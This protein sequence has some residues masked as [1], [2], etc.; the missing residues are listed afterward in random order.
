MRVRTHAVWQS[1][2]CECKSNW[3]FYFDLLD[4]R[5]F[6]LRILKSYK[7]GFILNVLVSHLFLYP[8]AVYICPSAVYICPYTYS[9][10]PHCIPFRITLGVEGTR[11]GGSITP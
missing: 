2:G 5:F 8:S 7:F 4:G 6:F 10:L 3:L 11:T 1:C 9:I